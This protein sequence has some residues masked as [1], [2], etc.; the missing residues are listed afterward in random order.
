MVR[1][2]STATRV[3]RGAISLSSSSHFPLRPYSNGVK[4]VAL[5]P[6]RARL[7]TKPAPTGS[8]TFANTIGTVRVA[9][10]RAWT[11]GVAAAKMTSGASASSSSAY[12]LNRP[13]SPAAQRWWSI[14]RLRPS[15]QPNRCS[16]C[17]NAAMRASPSGS[18]TARFMST[19]TRRTRSGCCARA[20]SSQPVAT[21]PMRVMNSR[22]LMG[23]PQSEDRTLAHRYGNAALCSTAKLAGQC[24]L[25]VTTRIDVRRAH[26]SSGQLRA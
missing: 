25:G 15:D 19:P 17:T 20:A 14:R 5:P 23:S 13:A 16:A 2:R 6:G 10:C 7:S 26:V 9:R 4:P 8:A 11:L 12:P 3:T 24:L 18:P 1:S 22:R 21:L